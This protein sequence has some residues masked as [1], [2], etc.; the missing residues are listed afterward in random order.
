MFNAEAHAMW[1][2]SSL[3]KVV[4]N[5][6]QKDHSPHQT[7]VFF[8][9][10]PLLWSCISH[11]KLFLVPPHSTAWC[12]ITLLV[13]QFGPPISPRSLF[14]H[15]ALIKPE[16]TALCHP[17]YCG[18]HHLQKLVVRAPHLRPRTLQ[19]ESFVGPS[20]QAASETI[21]PI[22]LYAL[23]IR[24]FA[25]RSLQSPGGTTKLS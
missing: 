2:P 11:P 25:G 9:F 12:R 13:R 21:S 20:E 24:R 5:H 3:S 15:A 22:I 19:G 14:S 23:R 6:R 17:A 10:L 8:E 1:T 4:V 18:H 16:Y 7:V